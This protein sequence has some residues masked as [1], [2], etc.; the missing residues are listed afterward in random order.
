MRLMLELDGE[1]GV[2][3]VEASDGGLTLARRIR[4]TGIRTRGERVPAA[5]SSVASLEAELERIIREGDTSA[6]K[7]DWRAARGRLDPV[8][9]RHDAIRETQ[10][11]HLWN[12]AQVWIAALV[13]FPLPLLFWSWDELF[14]NYVPHVLSG[15]AS[16]ASVYFLRQWWQNRPAA[17]GAAQAAWELERTLEGIELELVKFPPVVLPEELTARLVAESPDRLVVLLERF[18]PARDLVVL[19]SGETGRILSRQLVDQGATET[20]E[21]D[22]VAVTRG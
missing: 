12:V 7:A 6:L 21:G 16:A 5:A 18:A 17:A 11:Q 2:H 14:A 1:P 3:S 20:T 8:R 13:L 9:S 15:C 19:A 22:D 10:F 4:G